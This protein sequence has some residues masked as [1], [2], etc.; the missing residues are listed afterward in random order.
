M[1]KTTVSEVVTYIIK[2]ESR[3]G[4]DQ[5]VY[6]KATNEEVAYWRKNNQLQG[7]FEKNYG[8]ENCEPLYLTIPMIDKLLEDIDEGLEMTEGFFYGTYLL[9]AEETAALKTTFRS[10]QSALRGDPTSKYYYVCSY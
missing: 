9:D 8:I 4:L 6:N 5:S 7:W 10:I 2:K 1:I 3:M